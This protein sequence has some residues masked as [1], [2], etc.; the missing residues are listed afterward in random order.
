MKK[1]ICTLLAAIF[2]II[3]AA[4]VFAADLVA[5]VSNKAYMNGTV[6]ARLVA[7]RSY[8]IAMEIKNN[9]EKKES[10]AIIVTAYASGVCK[11]VSV[12][13]AEELASGETK[14]VTAAIDTVTGVDEVKCIVVKADGGGLFPVS[15]VVKS[16]KRTGWS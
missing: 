1:I 11:A 7:G 10:Y 6:Q 16:F 12:G 8:E 2:M 3:S 15:S 13:A 9:T 4:G 14:A 5:I